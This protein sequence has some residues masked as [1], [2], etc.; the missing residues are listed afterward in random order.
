LSPDDRPV[1]G[2]RPAGE[3][4]RELGRRAMVRATRVLFGGY[5][6]PLDHPPTAQS[7]PRWGHG[8]PVHARIAE[9]LAR[10]EDEYARTLETVLAYEDDL[11]RLPGDLWNTRWQ[12]NL[13]VAVLYALIRRHAPRRYVEIG[14]GV[15][16][17]VAARAKRDGRLDTRIASIDPGPRVPV[18]A[19]EAIAQPLE[20][21]DLSRFDELGPDD[22]V[23]MDGSH[24]AFMNSDAT[25]FFL[26]VLP[27]LRPGVVVGVHDVLLPEDYPPQWRHWHYS[28]QYL[29]AAYLLGG[30]ARIEPLFAARY[31]SSRAAVL[32]PLWERLGFTET[33]GF[34]FWLRITD[35]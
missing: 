1:A 11:A 32:A 20:V 27:R 16:T 13:D 10:H 21:A 17:A 15:S 3:R 4:V 8:R 7:R 23:F 25:V 12:P 29:L 14:S 5:V 35:R 9:I 33:G 34:A 22:V 30:A 31:M 28:E 2:R 18:A 19:D 26:D 6:A 24:R